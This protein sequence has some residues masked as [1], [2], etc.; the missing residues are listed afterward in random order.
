MSH[1]YTKRRIQGRGNV[2]SFCFCD[3]KGR[4]QASPPLKRI[5]SQNMIALDLIHVDGLGNPEP[6]GICKVKHC[7][8]HNRDNSNKNH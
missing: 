3:P 5:S 6:A 7:W 1:I 4:S 8:C 2:Y